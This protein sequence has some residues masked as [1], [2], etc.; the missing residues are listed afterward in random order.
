MK[1]TVLVNDF[2]SAF[3][4]SQYKDNFSR[5]ALTALFEYLECLE[6]EIGE[7]T[8]LDVCAISCEWTEYSSILGYLEDRGLSFED[9]G[10][11]P[12]EADELA[13]ANDDLSSEQEGT[14]FEWLQS[15]TSLIRMDCGFL[16][17]DC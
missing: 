9:V 6:D 7:E 2:I 1:T 5:D 17:Q 3:S 16:A 10:I 12:D 13:G 11:D 15:E 14:F 4:L 8:E